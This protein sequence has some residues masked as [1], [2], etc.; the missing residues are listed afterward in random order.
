[1]KKRTLTLMTLL[2]IASVSLVGCGNSTGNSINT[3]NDSVIVENTISANSAEKIVEQF[4][5]AV[6]SGD[7]TK[8][9]SM[10][11]LPEG[12][13]G[14]AKA[15]EN[16]LLK[17]NISPVD[18]KNISTEVTGQEERKQVNVTVLTKDEATVTA[19][20]TAVLN[21]NNKW[22]I[23]GTDFCV[24]DWNVTV[25]KG[26]TVKLNG[27]ILT[28]NKTDKVVN[29]G[30][31]N[32]IT[33]EQYTI[34]AIIKGN[35][36]L[37]VEHSLA[38]TSLEEKVYPGTEKVVDLKLTETGLE[39]VKNALITLNSTIIEKAT[40]K[41]DFGELL[42]IVDE[43]SPSLPAM[44]TAYEDL[45]TKL[46]ETEKDILYYQYKDLKIS[47]IS[48]TNAKYMGDDKVYIEGTYDSI[49]KYR[50]SSSEKGIENSNWETKT[51]KL[52]FKATFKVV[53]GKYLQVS[54][55]GIYSLI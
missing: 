27:E 1:M 55:Q 6:Y 26:A 15:L 47:N 32:E 14:N 7:Y 21:D 25:P 34:P 11:E 42:S 24:Y 53:D 44:Q 19:T 30:E 54:G 50:Y 38:E 41:A 52:D 4:A 12:S 51:N 5:K 45:S 29:A 23:D 31:K 37:I 35:Y 33:Y 3:G 22:V 9:L 10:I 13:I 46:T 39:E 43:T 28:A 40:A 2:A 48:I 18:V 49:Y 17:L 20:F 16:I 36:E 8:A